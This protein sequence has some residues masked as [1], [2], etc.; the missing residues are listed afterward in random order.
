MVPEAIPQIKKKGAERM[1]E[2]TDNTAEYVLRQ[3]IQDL[4][5]EIMEIKAGIPSQKEEESQSNWEKLEDG[6]Q[7]NETSM[8]IKD[9][10]GRHI[11]DIKY[12]SN[13]TGATVTELRKK[14]FLQKAEIAQQQRFAE[15]KDESMRNAYSIFKD[16]IQETMKVNM[17]MIQSLDSTVIGND[18]EHVSLSSIKSVD[19][20]V[21]NSK[22]SKAAMPEI[23]T[24]D[25]NQIQEQIKIGS[26]KM[27][28]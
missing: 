16:Q 1:R 27:D 18:N 7:G 3:E 8:R 14:L 10:Q 5:G 23:S 13:T 26:W 24:A 19:S 21:N 15:Q 25:G 9:I 28:I 4:K 11:D 22:D 17:D 2:H 6:G 20:K 12:D